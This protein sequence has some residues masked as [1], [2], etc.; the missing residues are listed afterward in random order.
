M[1]PKFSL[2]LICLVRRTENHHQRIVALVQAVGGS[3][4]VN[5]LLPDG[6]RVVCTSGLHGGAEEQVRPQTRLQQ[7]QRHG[8]DRVSTSVQLHH[9]FHNNNQ[10]TIKSN[11]YK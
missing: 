11:K 8:V 2:Q 4:D 10:N 5:D 1:K 6:V 3:N 7:R 9:L